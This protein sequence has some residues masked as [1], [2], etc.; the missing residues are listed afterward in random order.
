MLKLNLFQRVDSG[1]VRKTVAIY[2]QEVAA[3]KQQKT[4]ALSLTLITLHNFISSVFLPLLI[5]FFT[6]ALIANKADVSKPIFLLTF[7]VVSSVL[8]IVVQ[9][10]GFN[11][12]FKHEE[13]ITTRLHERSMRGLLA[14]SFSFFANNKTGALA[15]DANTFSRSYITVMDS[16]ALKANGILVNFVTSLVVVAFI[17]PAMLPLLVAL[18]VIVIYE[19]LLSY[20]KRAQYRIKRKEMQSKLFGTIADVLGNQTLVRM[21]GRTEQ[22]IQTVV[23]ERKDIEQIAQK[24]ITDLQNTSAVRTSIVFGF[25]ILT[26]ATCLWLIH[27][28]SLS[29]AALIFIITYLGRVTGSMFSINDIVRTLEQ[30]FLD[31]N[32]VTEILEM[33]IEVTD[34]KDA[35]ELKIDKA[36]IDIKNVSFAYSD[37]LDRDVLRGLTLHIPHGQSVGLVGKS[38][39]GKST[40]THLL[41]R[42]MDVTAGEIDIDGQNIA[43]VTQDSL[44][45]AISYVPQDSF[46]FHRSL[47]ENIAYGK[48]SATDKEILAAAKQAHALEFIEKLPRGLDT[49]VGER[50]VKLSGGQRQRV[51]IARAILKDAPILVLDEATSALDSESEALIQD[52]LW[53]LMEGRT[54][55]VIA[56]RLSTIQ[57]MDRIVVLDEGKIIEQGTHKELI[58]KKTGVYAGLWARQSGGFIED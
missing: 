58:A 21:F 28:N 30:A 43:H 1:S 2:K 52:A 51:A 7:M 41:L 40:L 37:A 57:K 22:E 29:V 42:Y 14:H 36:D 38:G 11:M 12:L 56:H 20:S 26:M 17:A 16:L 32:K 18:T 49:V 31:A 10:A 55:I 50:G 48:P 15:G 25:Q 13:F 53:K 33:P 6:Q 35:R 46:L 44:R 24:E 23:G 54:A 4:F 34:A 9:H 3:G 5:S 39:G 45:Q 8:D 47:R 19:S 27:K